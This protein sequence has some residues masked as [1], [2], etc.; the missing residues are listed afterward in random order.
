MT[1]VPASDS[2]KYLPNAIS[3]HPQT[4]PGRGRQRGGCRSW[5]QRIRIIQKIRWKCY[6]G[7]GVPVPFSEEDPAHTT[8]SLI[9]ARSQP[10]LLPWIPS[11]YETLRLGDKA[12]RQ[13]LK[14]GHFPVHYTA[15]MTFLAYKTLIV[16]LTAKQKP[17]P[18]KA[19]YCALPTPRSY[20][21]VSDPGSP[22]Q[23]EH[24][25]NLL[26]V[27]RCSHSSGEVFL[28]YSRKLKGS[29][30]LL[31]QESIFV[32]PPQCNSYSL[33]SGFTEHNPTIKPMQ[34]P[35]SKMFENPR[36]GYIASWLVLCY[37]EGSSPSS[38]WQQIWRLAAFR[39]PPA[40]GFGGW[41]PGLP[42][43]PS[44][45]KEPCRWPGEP[46]GNRATT[47]GSCVTG[48]GQLSPGLAGDGWRKD[49]CLL[50]NLPFRSTQQLAESHYS[51]T[52]C[53]FLSNTAALHNP[54]HLFDCS[55]GTCNTLGL[56]H[57]NLDLTNSSYVPHH[58]FIIRLNCF[59]RTKSCKVSQF[60]RG[61]GHPPSLLIHFT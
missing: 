57:L 39:D 58:L 30:R 60:L 52:C 5:L 43:A 18:L 26:K 25:A 11:G 12:G 45:Q 56:F 1:D 51:P 49:L 41:D 9:P 20:L 7:H 3:S 36:G 38:S 44:K 31:R 35:V 14:K 46:M 27:L 6:L 28:R 8:A 48:Y 4:D 17:N 40:P 53:L 34:P 23:W 50:S 24:P 42:S 19:W 59:L 21:A 33:A 22:S 10:Q 61:A 55:L 37:R 47:P 16:M 15:K 54:N 29:R 2:S 13:K 32:V